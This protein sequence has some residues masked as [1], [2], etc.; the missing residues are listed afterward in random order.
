MD[1]NAVN[2]DPAV[3]LVIAAHSH[4]EVIDPVARSYVFPMIPLAH[5]ILRNDTAVFGFPLLQV[6]NIELPKVLFI[7]RDSCSVVVGRK[8]ETPHCTQPSMR[9]P[10]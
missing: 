3:H 7:Y 8:V 6:M 2:A 4:S 9:D 10:A 5:P 1:A